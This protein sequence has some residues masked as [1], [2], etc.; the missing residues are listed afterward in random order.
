MKFLSICSGIEAASIA[1]APLGWE[2]V[3]FSEIEAF[4]SA[5][6]D[7]RHEWVPNLGDMTRFDEWPEHLLAEVDMIVGGPPCQSFS[8]AGLRGG[9]D[10]HRG[11]LTLVYFDLINHVDTIR[12]KHGK[13][14]VIAIYENVPGLLSDKTNAFGGLLAG[15]AGE[16]EALVVPK[17]P[18]A[19]A[20]DGRRR[21]VAWC[22]LDAQYFGVAQRRR[23][24]FVV[25]VPGE[26]V[27]H[28]GG[29]LHPAEILS[30]G[31]GLRRDT[32]TRREA[33][34]N[35]TSDVGSSTSSRGDGGRSR[36]PQ[37]VSAHRMVAFGEYAD[38][39]TASTI[40]M[41]D[42][43]DATDLVVHGTQDPCVSDIAFALGRN[44][45]QENAV[46]PVQNALRGKSQNGLGIA[47]S[48]EPMYTLDQGSQHAVACTLGARAEVKA[49]SISLRG[50]EGG[51]TAELGGEVSGCIRASSGGGDKP[52]ALISNS[53]R[54]LTP[55]ECERL[56]GF[57]DNHT[58]I[59]WRGKPAEQCPDGPRYK[60]I[61]N[62]MAVPVMA[63][64]GGRLNTA[65]LTRA[66]WS[67]DDF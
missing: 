17:W 66:D 18:R 1:F 30:I 56:Q 67:E 48:G 50:R 54:R 43:K 3:A 10:D 13:P 12:K 37:P 55:I 21:R 58:Q 52:H 22:I 33:R 44:S 20:V 14:P 65:L 46:F 35:A 61:G 41:R 26:L 23:R 64:I 31:K 16:D 19:G 59:P 36:G 60:A 47:D 53:V 4:T 7:Q 63:W 62:S 8:V 42:Y 5:I 38:D 40:K 2:P 57:P 29:R 45:G 24:V 51:A 27:E 28:S 39:D 6:L 25:A 32:P 15:L 9:L 49:T 34:E 11:N